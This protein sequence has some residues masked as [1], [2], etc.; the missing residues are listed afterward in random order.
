MLRIL[1]LPIGK[2][3]SIWLACELIDACNP[4]YFEV[5]RTF[6]VISHHPDIGRVSDIVELSSLRNLRSN[7]LRRHDIAVSVNFALMSQTNSEHFSHEHID[8]DVKSLSNTDL[9]ILL[10]YST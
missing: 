1:L 8:G 6:I 5:R 7:H 4:Y 10:D 9:M 3:V 2:M